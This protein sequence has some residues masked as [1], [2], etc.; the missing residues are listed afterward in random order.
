MQNAFHINTLNNR[1]FIIVVLAAALVLSACGSSSSNGGHS[2]PSAVDSLSGDAD[3]EGLRFYY[4]GNSEG[5]YAI[6]PADPG[7]LPVLVDEDASPINTGFPIIAADLDDDTLTNSSV[8]YVLYATDE[9]IYRVSTDPSATP[10]PVRVS[11]ESAADEICGIRFTSHHPEQPQEA[12][13]IYSKAYTDAAGV[14]DCE[15]AEAENA[16]EWFQVRLD[17]DENTD[18]LAFP[19]AHEP[20]SPVF[21][22][23]ADS[24]TGWLALNHIDGTLHEVDMDDLS[25]G[26]AMDG[27]FS[28][29]PNQEPLED[30]EHIEEL[31]AFSLANGSVL[32]PVLPPGENEYV[33]FRYDPGTGS[34]P[35]QLVALGEAMNFTFSQMPLLDQEHFADAEAMF[36]VDQYV[37]GPTRSALYRAD[38]NGLAIIDTAD[39]GGEGAFAINA[40]ERVVWSR[41][42]GAQIVVSSVNKDGSGAIELDRS[43]A[44]MIEANVLGASENGWVYFTRAS[45]FDPINN[46]LDDPVAVATRADGSGGFE[47]SH[48]RWLGSSLP[49]EGMPGE[50]LDT[51]SEVFVGFGDEIGAVSAD[52]PYDEIVVLGPLPNSHPHPSMMESAF[53]FGPHRLLVASDGG[54]PPTKHIIYVNTRQSESLLTFTDIAD[55]MT[56]PIPGF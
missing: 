9:H 23:D 36:F 8:A 3:F 38:N 17:D 54:S 28:T 31:S 42:E 26:P 27:I 37:G 48:W 13:V 55:L 5:L 4:D 45:G 25:V 41:H 24:D 14:D 47:A 49:A 2:L 22:P 15:D 18:P 20:V 6:D 7:D 39:S 10:D 32:L 34:D 1:L 11:S 21:D 33:L 40:G 51:P 53:G 50:A 16:F 46:T 43:S 30:I 44:A 19:T 29:I 56:R 35:G 52:A 12:A